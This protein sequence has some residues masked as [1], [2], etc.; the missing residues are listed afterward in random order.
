MHT[1]QPGDSAKLIEAGQECCAKFSADF[2]FSPFGECCLFGPVL[3][4]DNLSLSVFGFEASNEEDEDGE[5]ED[6]EILVNVDVNLHGWTKTYFRSLMQWPFRSYGRLLGSGPTHTVIEYNHR[7]AVYSTDFGTE[8]LSVPTEGKFLYL[9]DYDI[10]SRLPRPEGLLS[11][12]PLF[13]QHID[14]QP[15]TPRAKRV[16]PNV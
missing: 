8:I 12:S 11:E 2:F 13:V 9:W 5:F 10:L 4:N 3:S 7:I 1:T 14:I 15:S 16:K 6:K